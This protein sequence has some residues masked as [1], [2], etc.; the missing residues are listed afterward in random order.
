MT[1]RLTL[2]SICR[3][4]TYILWSGLLLHILKTYLM[5]K[6]CTWDNGSVQLKDQPY[7][8]YMG[9]RPIFHGPLILPYIIVIDKLFLYI[10]KWH[11]PGVFVSLQALA[12][13]MLAAKLKGLALPHP[14]ILPINYVQVNMTDLL[15]ELSYIISYRV[16]QSTIYLLSNC[17]A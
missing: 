8:I 7:K 14:F 12:L 13:V 5:E 2:L 10:K 3:S 1:H 16:F 6:C 9:Q 15:P 11:R 4:V 17:L